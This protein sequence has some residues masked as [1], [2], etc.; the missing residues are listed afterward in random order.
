VGLDEL[1]CGLDRELVPWIERPVDALANEEVVLP[2]RGC[3]LRFGDVL[4]EHGDVHGDPSI[5]RPEDTRGD[6][7]ACTS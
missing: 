2:E 7:G 4:D 6:G 5:G 1:E 3:P